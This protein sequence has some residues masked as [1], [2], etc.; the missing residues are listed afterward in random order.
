MKCSEMDR[1][2]CHLAA[3]GDFFSFPA[4]GHKADLHFLRGKIP[5]ETAVICILEHSD[6]VQIVHMPVDV[7]V[8]CPD[9]TDIPLF[10]SVRCFLNAKE[11]RNV[12]RN[13]L[14]K[15][16]REIDR[17]QAQ[18]TLPGQAEHTALQ[19]SA[20]GDLSMLQD[21]LNT[22]IRYI[23]Q[24]LYQEAFPDRMFSRFVIQID[25][26][27]PYDEG[28]TKMVTLVKPQLDQRSITIRCQVQ[29]S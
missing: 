15:I 23:D 18:G 29:P 13:I 25:F 21:K 11:I 7:Q 26:L 1:I 27:H 10:R 8:G 24:K 9:R 16:L 19:L 6:I 14:G 12:I 17:G 22:Y 4:L 28:F 3:D 20:G 2:F 5:P